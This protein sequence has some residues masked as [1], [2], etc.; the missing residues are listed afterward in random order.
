MRLLFRYMLLFNFKLCSTAASRLVLNRSDVI[1][2]L[3][4]ADLP[5][6]PVL[7]DM[8]ANNLCFT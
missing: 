2:A 5:L 7:T 4:G 8:F 1:L 3:P 6:Q